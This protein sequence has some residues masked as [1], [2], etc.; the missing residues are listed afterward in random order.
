[1]GLLINI[2][3]SQR[4]IN[5]KLVFILSFFSIFQLSQVLADSCHMLCQCNGSTCLSC[6]EG[7]D[8]SSNSIPSSNGTCSCPRGFYS[9]NNACL[10]CSD[11]CDS[12]LS[13]TVCVECFEGYTK[14]NGSCKLVRY[15]PTNSWVSYLV[16]EDF[17]T[18]AN[19]SKSIFGMSFHDS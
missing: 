12:C 14:I 13:S 9:T 19:G 18:L 16:G 5:S 10:F 6:F 8:I 11:G 15:D 17:K 7:F 4:M 3:L 2:K 1:M